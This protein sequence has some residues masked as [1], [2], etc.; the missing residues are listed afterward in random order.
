MLKRI[1][2]PLTHQQEKALIYIISTI[3][4]KG[5]PPTFAE[6]ERELGYKNPGSISRLLQGL[7]KKGYIS[8]KKHIP[9]GIRLTALS[10]DISLLIYK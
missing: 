4:T 3:D 5:Y 1:R 2:L 10:E 9:R 8:R 7:E 6:I